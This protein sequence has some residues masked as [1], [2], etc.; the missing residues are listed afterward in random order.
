MLIC[1]K[2]QDEQVPVLMTSPPE[3]HFNMRTTIH[4]Y[5]VVRNSAQEWILEWNRWSFLV[6]TDKFFS[7]LAEFRRAEGR[8][9][10][11]IRYRYPLLKQ[12]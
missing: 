1:S 11:T 10:G 4:D 6:K 5:G 8:F 9:K 2:Y 12:F 3:P 7:F